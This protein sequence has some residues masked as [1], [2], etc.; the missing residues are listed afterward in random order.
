ME[1]DFSLMMSTMGSLVCSAG[2]L[3][4]YIVNEKEVALPRKFLLFSATIGAF[5][6]LYICSI[7]QWSLLSEMLDGHVLGKEFTRMHWVA[8]ML[9]VAGAVVLYVQWKKR[10]R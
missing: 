1:S 8:G 5:L 2:L 7:Q 3:F 4:I 10:K 9:Y 6:I